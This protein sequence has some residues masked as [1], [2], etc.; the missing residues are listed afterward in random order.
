MQKHTC[1]WKAVDILWGGEKAKDSFREYCFIL[2]YKA[3]V[4]C[5]AHYSLQEIER[6]ANAF[7]HVRML[8][9]ITCDWVH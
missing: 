2:K 8:S 7:S 5:F 9:R 3:Y 1:F 4:H 6:E